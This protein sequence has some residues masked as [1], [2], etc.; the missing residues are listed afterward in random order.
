MVRC[1]HY[2]DV[3]QRH[4]AFFADVSAAREAAQRECDDTD[5]A[6]QA[7]VERVGETADKLVES[8]Q[9]L[10]AGLQRRRQE[11]LDKARHA[12]TGAE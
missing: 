1:G 5:A 4:D 3:F 12:E 7:D 11:W 6:L 8:L 10:G 2:D 9:M